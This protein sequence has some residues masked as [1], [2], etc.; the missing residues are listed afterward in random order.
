[1][2]VADETSDRDS[3]TAK[4]KAEMS[5]W[6]RKVDEAVQSAKEKGTEGSAAASRELD[7]AWAKTKSAAHQLENASADGWDSAKAK[8]RKAEDDL[9]ATWRKVSPGNK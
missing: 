6:Q 1:M 7:T 9:A 2:P 8:F 3:F 5:D 4:A